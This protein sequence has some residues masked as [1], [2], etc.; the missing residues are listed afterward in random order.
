MK[1][2]YYAVVRW[3]PEDIMAIAEG[4]GI[5]MTREEAERWF[6]DHENGIKQTLTEIG[7]EML[8][9]LLV[10]EYDYFS[11]RL[12][13]VV[14][15]TY[16][17]TWEDNAGEHHI[18]T[19]CKVNLDTKQVFDIKNCP[20]INWTEISLEQIRFVENEHERVEDVYGPHACAELDVAPGEVYY[21]EFEH[22]HI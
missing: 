10:E 4:K 19:P 2:K 20:K 7:N 3:M 13:R 17:L 8:S 9:D 11:H 18:E 15:A 5:S 22:A 14:S 1:E 16:E 21:R 6:K 12:S